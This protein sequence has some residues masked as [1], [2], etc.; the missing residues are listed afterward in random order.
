MNLE[1]WVPDVAGLPRT[2]HGCDLMSEARI[3]S[4]TVGELPAHVATINTDSCVFASVGVFDLI[5]EHLSVNRSNR[6]VS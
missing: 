1:V 4:L 6:T 3:G 5:R 2:H